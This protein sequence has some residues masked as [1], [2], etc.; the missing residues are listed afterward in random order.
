MPPVFFLL[1]VSFATKVKGF[2]NRMYRHLLLGSFCIGLL[3][4]PGKSADPSAPTMERYARLPLAFE[5]QAAGSSERF[6][7]RGQGYVIGL[8]G[9]KATV[10]V[11]SAKDK[12]DHAVSL[13][14]AGSR[15]SHAV[16]GSELAGKV[17]YLRGNDPKSWQVGLS[18]YARVT[19]PE[20]YPGIDV[21]YYG[22]QQQLEFDLVVKPGADPEAIRLKVEGA[23]KL[24]IDA[25]GALNLGEAGGGLKVA[26]PQIYQ[27]LNGTKKSVPGHYA[28]VGRDEVAFRLDPWDHTRPLV[29]DPTIVYSSLFGSPQ[30]YAYAEA[31]ALDSSG[32]IVIS[33]YADGGFPTL[34]AAQSV[35]KGGPDLFVTKINAAGTALI[36]STYLGG[37][38]YQYSARLAV[39]S[40]GAA[41][42]TGYTSSSDFPVKNAAQPTLPGTYSAFVTRLDA[43]GAL[44]FSTYLGGTS[45]T[46]GEGIAVDS[47]NNGYVTGQAYGA[48]PTTARALQTSSG[49]AFVTKYAPGG[50][51]TWST[52]LGGPSTY[53]SAVAVDSAFNV[54]VTGDS[55]DSN[56]T[57]MPSGGAQTANSGD[58]DAFV[59]KIN[60][61]ATAYVYFTFL[62]GTGFDQGTAIAVDS[63]F[64]A[65]IAGNTSSTGLA[66]SGAAY[67]TL[68]GGTNGFAAELNPAGSKFSY[69]TYIGG[70][71]VEYV[72]GL[73][74]DGSDNVYLTG[75][76]DSNTFPTV[77]PLQ[78]AF[79]GNGISLF[80]STNS[81][82]TWAAFD[83]NIPGAVVGLSINP[84]G[85]STVVLTDSGI[86]RTVNGGASWSRQSNVQF[87]YYNESAI[88]RSPVAPGTLYAVQC[89][90]SVYR[91]TDDGVTWTYRGDSGSGGQGGILADPKTANTVYVY[92][93]QSPYVSVSTDGGA[94]F[95]P[96]GTGLPG[97]VESLVGTTDGSLYANALGS[98][99][100]KSTNQGGS[101]AAVNTGLPTTPYAYYA[102]SLS[103]SGTTVYFATEGMIYETT[104]GGAAWAATPTSVNAYAVAASPQNP[105]ILYALTSN[106]TVRESTDGGSTWNPAGT[107]L[108]ST[109]YSYYDSALVV[110]PTNSAHVLLVDYVFNTGFVA[111]LNNTGTALAWSTYLGAAEET[112]AYGVATDGTGDA[113]VTG[114]SFGIGFPVTSTALPGNP[115]SY[116]FITKISDATAPCSALTVSP[117]STYASQYGGT[118][119]FNVVAPSGCAWQAGSNQPWATVTGGASGTA[120]GVVTVQ[121]TSNSS[122]ATQ[123]ATLAVGSRNVTITQPANTCFY[124]LDMESY[125]VGTGG[126]TVSAQLTATAGCPW[127]MTNYYSEAISFTSASSGTGSATI[128]MKVAP[129]LSGG[130]LNFSLAVGT[131]SIDIVEAGG[132]SAQTITFDQIP[133]QILGISPF[134]VAAQSSALLPVGFK[135]TTTPVCTLADDIVTLLKAG[136]CSITAS[137]PG[138]GSY[139]AATPVMRSFT[140]SVAKISGSFFAAPGNP[141]AVGRIPGS[142]AVGDFNGDGIRDLAVANESGNSVTLLLGNGAGGFMPAAGSPFAVGSIPSSVVVGDFNG[143]GIPD[144]ATANNV[145]NNVTVLLGNGSGGFTAAAGSPF[146]AGTS[147]FSVVVGDFNGDGIQDLATGNLDSAT[148][149]VLLGNGSGGFTP[150]PGSPFAVG[151]DPVSV[152]V[153]DF[154]GDGIQDLAVANENDNNVTVLLGNG[155][156]GFAAANGSPFA[157]GDLP[158]F[159]VVGDFDADGIQDLA[160][161]NSAS[162]NVTVLLG[163]G[164]GGFTEAPASPF[165][166]GATPGSVVV[167]DFNGDGIQD[168]A[169]AN[170]VSNNVTVL[171]GNGSGAFA[172]MTGSPFAAGA[173]AFSVVTGDFNGDGIE[174]LATANFGSNNVTVLLGAVVGTTPQTITFGPLSNVTY[175]V[176]PFTIGATSNSELAVSFASTTFGVCTVAGTTVTIV[177]AGA[178]TII[179]SQAGNGIYAAAATV[180]RS[181]TVTPDSQ[182]ITFAPL[183]NQ[184]LGVSPFAVNATASSGLAVSFGSTTSGVCTVSGNA[185]TIVGT[186]TCTITANQ[187]GNFDYTAAPQVVRSFMVEG[188]TAQTIT[189]DKI[190]TQILGI[191]PFPIAAQASSLLAVGLKSLTTAVCT[192]A[193]DLVTL[194]TAG[195]CTITA[196]QPGNGSYSA[197]TSVTRSF[198]VNQA[199]VSGSF[200]LAAGSPFAAG[201]TPDAAVAG[202][203]NG[204]GIPDL[205]IPNSNSASVTILLGNGTGGYAPAPGSPFPAGTNPDSVATGDFNGDGKLDLAFANANGNVTVLL[206]NGSGGF[207]VA[208]GSPFAAGAF[209]H[210]V[211]VGDFNGDGIQDLAVANYN[212]NSVTVLLGNGSG[213]FTAAAGSPFAV[214]TNPSAVAVGDFNRDGNL[215]LAIANRGDGTVTTL[216]GDGVGGFTQGPGSPFTVGAA[217]MSLAVGD[218]NGDGIDDVA[219]ANS[220]DNTVTI[221]LGD[222]SGWL[223]PSSGS[224]FAVGT[225]PSWVVVGDFNGDG[226]QDLA[227]ANSGSNNLTV[228]LGDGSGNFATMTGSPLAVG[229]SPASLAVEDFNGDGIEDLAVPNNL[230]NNVTVLLGAVVGSTPQ[231]ITFGPLSNVTYGVLPFAVSATSTSELGVGFFST[232]SAVCTVAGGSVTIVATGTCTIAASQAGNPDFAAAPTVMQSFTVT[233]AA[234]TI[235]FAPLSNQTLGVSPFTVTATASS[236]L[237]VAFASTTSGVCTIPANS[238]TVTIGGT[239]TCTIT[240]NQAGNADYAAAPQ[241]TRNFMV[242][243]ST[244]QTITFDKIPNQ[245]YGISPFPIAA[246]A[247]SLLAVGLKSTTTAVCT[248]ADDLVTLLKAGTCTII[249]SQPG[250][251]TYSAA[252]SVTRSFTV[253]QA[254]LSRSFVEAAGGP[255]AA[256]IQ[257][258]SVATGDFN[259]DGIPD[260]ATANYGSANVTVLLGNRSGGF[261]P[262]AGSPFATETSPESVAVGDFNGDGIQDLAVANESGTLTVLLGNGSGG[263]T[264][265][266]G[267]PF[268]AGV[269]P[270]AIAIGDFN[271]DG[272]QDLAVANSDGSLT[273]LLGNGSGGFT[274]TAGTSFV[275]GFP[276]SVVVGDFNGDGIADLATA[277]TG[278]NNVTV[279]LGNGSGGFTPAPGSPFAAGTNPGSLVVGDFNGDGIQDLATANYGSYNVTVLLG[280]GSGGFAAA[281]GSPFGVGTNPDSVVVGDFNGDGI[282]DLATANYGSDN[283]TVLVGT[284]SG[285]FTPMTGGPLA[286]GASPA[287]LAVA[288][289]NGDGIEDLA[290]ANYGSHNVTVLLGA[291]V[292]TTPQTITFGPLS[293]V[294]NGVAPFTISATSNSELAVSFASTTSAVCTV[295]GSTVTII[296]TGTCTIIASQAGDNTYAAAATVTQSFTVNPSSQSPQT[297]TFSPLPNQVYGSV[298]PA[299]SATASSGLTVTFISQ[300]TS[301]CTLSGANGTIVKLHAVGTCTIQATQSGNAAYSASTP[302]NQSFMVTQ[303]P[304]SI[305]FGPLTNEPFGSSSPTLSATASSG[306]PVSFN[307]QTQSVCVVS[308]NTVTLAAPGFCTIQAT[309]AGNADYTAAIPV[310][311]SFTITPASQTISFGALSPQTLGST[312]PPLSATASSGLSV[313]F[314]STTASICTVSGT[315]VTLVAAGTCT[316]QATQPGTANFAAA[317]PVTQSFTV[318]LTKLTITGTGNL[319]GFLPGANVSGTVTASGGQ[320]PYKFSATGLPMGFNLNAASGA[321]GGEAP[322]PGAYSFTLTASDSGTPA[323]TA[324]FTVSFSVLGI[325]TSSLPAATKGGSYSQQIGAIGGATPYSFSAT[326]LGGSGLSLSSSGL[327]SGTPTTVGTLSLTVQVTDAKGLS[328]S[329]NLSLVI[330]NPAGTVSGPLSAPGGT[331]TS[332]S[333]GSSYSTTVT[334]TGGMP[335]YTWTLV[336]GSLPDGGVTLNNT[337]AITGTPKTPGTYTF[338]AQAM[339]AAGATSLGT[340]TLAIIPAV[341]EVASTS[342]PQ[343]IATV[344]YP[345]QIMSATGGV[346]PYTF[347][348]TAGSLPAGL[349]F[350]SGQI[351]GTPTAVGTFGF[352]L[353]VTDSTKATASAPVSITVNPFSVNLLVSQSIAAFSLTVGSNGIPASAS[354]TIQ[355]DDPSQILNYS[356]AVTPAAPWLAVTSGTGTTPGSVSIALD[357]SALSL[358]ASDT[359]Y[360]ATVNVTC[361]A[362]SPCAGDTQSITAQLT[363]TAPAP[364]ITITGTLVSFAALT[365][366]PGPQSQPLGIQNSGGGTLQIISVTPADSWL[367]VTGVP[368]S[369]VA[370]PAV[371]MTVTANSMG[372]DANFYRSTLTAVTSAGTIVVPVT[373][374]VAQSVTM[375]LS[376]SG[377]TIQSV[378]GNPPGSLTG[379]FS[380][381]VTGGGSINW[382]AQVLPGTPW[383]SVSTPSGIATANTPGTVNFAIDPTLAAGLAAQAYAGSIQ[384]TSSD[385]VNSPLVFQLFLNVGPAGSP[386]SPQTSSGGFVFTANTLESSKA[387]FVY[388][389]SKTP[390]AYQASAA[391][392]DGGTWLSVNPSTGFSSASVPAQSVISTNAAGLAPGVYRGGVTY[393]FLSNVVSTVNITLLVGTQGASTTTTTSSLSAPAAISTAAAGCAPT[394]LVA[395][396]TGLV[397]NFAQPAGW[398]TLLAVAVNDDCL[399][400][401]TDAQVTL[402]FSNGDPAQLMTFNNSTQT[403]VYTW[404]PVNVASQVTVA[405][406]ATAQGLASANVRITGEVRPNNPPILVA[407]T[408]THVFNPV[409]GG[410]LAPGSIVSIYGSNLAA[411]STPSSAP[412]GTNLGNTS[413]VIGGTYAPLYYVSPGQIN[414]QVPFG[415]TPGNQYQVIVVANGIPTATPATIQLTPAVPGIAAFATSD[416]GLFS[417]GE[418]IAQ[419]AADYSLVTQASPAVPGESLIFYLAGLGATD[420][421][422]GTGQPASANPLSHALAPVTLTLNGTVL[423]TE[424]A[425]L[426][427]TAVGLYQV[428]F[429]VPVGTPSGNL[430]L[431]VSQ[432]GAVSNST[433]LPVK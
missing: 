192:L 1:F 381:N 87:Y 432:S 213:G 92:G 193:D 248:L 219:V 28:I 97:Q 85:T 212:G 65:F 46:Y 26:L 425:G 338:T 77:L 104:N 333:A 202:D 151:G 268:A 201:T 361:I 180:T 109:L 252:T 387:V 161:A 241:V 155:S 229:A 23:G 254:K 217:P 113:F 153:G 114:F 137:Q 210:S 312:P 108:P 128:T 61:T 159:L 349:T 160:I 49:A 186:G 116:A 305:T 84:A 340:F 238:N 129:N 198:T 228:L 45:N 13:E 143:D 53:G 195:T 406:L 363:V 280:N 78:S 59:A 358:S 413:V 16:P 58:G 277:N 339:D 271:G 68:T 317:T 158:F 86:Y 189:F 131:A 326:G 255:F 246:Q 55:Y 325:T 415:L 204:D 332:G 377:A 8:N 234:Q 395:S 257:P 197:A 334:A 279:L 331:L 2:A 307:S 93:D 369:L 272:I 54:Y 356:V 389:S 130:A 327:L 396:Q 57:G 265:A 3:A 91:S 90:S 354:V 273:V 276:F 382:T 154:N 343:G 264:P 66:T 71:R 245:I 266:A 379:S 386:P 384:V 118:L 120:V 20:V 169:T 188:S 105:S 346:S 27:D 243:G 190:P 176:S 184:T 17:N 376:P 275:G 67:T 240:A 235:T 220:T 216:F 88:S 419:H 10:L 205:A 98:G 122:G 267:S 373:L 237:A 79:P 306:L 285:G 35:F 73:A 124:S 123:T 278:F 215:D 401:V 133:N 157:V 15:P 371:P 383:L 60:P 147:P 48:F 183:S 289:F 428:D 422:V 106:D 287:S 181:F 44:Q 38:G 429:Q 62:G 341:L 365:G 236:G 324:N 380:V 421:P 191:S 351:S 145:S 348:I 167:G 294:T 296:A 366:N 203:F 99:I 179:A 404:T 407:N 100:Y 36:Y 43:A 51:V 182:T 25:S 299:L 233:R 200:G 412:L 178:C 194:L 410:S 372:L 136:T 353:T 347:S 270:D 357:P 423:P 41:W 117:A 168:L 295:Q 142:V 50:A 89:C 282:Q 308:G 230:D 185:V 156:G 403:Y 127:A 141:F 164:S 102:Q 390:V 367:S 111:K 321:F 408:P 297:I 80:N 350:G 391:T 337:G 399:N 64:N 37:S 322:A 174:D 165:A 22:N 313:S 414:A 388:A 177:G 393:A 146:A 336:G 244:A 107:G 42:V 11:S 318:S 175:G 162:N 375:T 301:V 218:F 232:T 75:Y 400:T 242:E 112:Y 314:A 310:S 30:S 103:A 56:F 148:V 95:T 427:P 224:P 247:S 9:G 221:L 364:Q 211:T 115:E 173:Y 251:S 291:V 29:I 223:P 139:S 286:V 385:V 398:P 69:V 63:S 417:Q 196:S 397:S 18:T 134:P 132:V 5:K 320:P 239:G 72:Q 293:N 290:T 94:T 81:G 12:T 309:Q 47:Q 433:L 263:F 416:T 222:S 32:N 420:N 424:F 411:A 345:L 260:V 207:A 374:N 206:G 261:T 172:A 259:G 187:P 405:G 227:T 269:D 253:N 368:S 250:N 355:S 39:D 199:N 409:I 303:A 370:G 256:G 292:G 360:Q 110:D 76:T 21:V 149:T 300:T 34:N 281:P 135:S 6:V 166:V 352:T 163:N 359:P 274:A 170:N 144:L 82:G 126:G 96:A 14:F 208:P 319:G 138:N 231:T 362:P 101:W 52:L 226:I 4:V 125:A 121:T 214:G 31:I 328:T 7:A 392:T 304:Q 323:A 225:T 431:V 298:P 283:V 140:V 150:A 262:A 74:L 258:R 249:A 119:T 70:N 418:I 426:T 302:V 284:G 288:D 344:P 311:Q 430:P 33:G 152:V 329:A 24:S 394:K 315:A 316:I 19:Y 209:P 335:P 171:L 402:S 378:A 330:N 40:T 342:F 83:T